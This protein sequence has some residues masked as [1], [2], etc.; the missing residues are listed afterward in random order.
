LRIPGETAGIR[1]PDVSL[2]AS[3]HPGKASIC[4]SWRGD[5]P[6]GSGF[7]RKKGKQGYPC[8]NPN[9]RFMYRGSLFSGDILL[10]KHR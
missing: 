10:L 6:D 1:I 5:N 3:R 2:H 9:S 4:Q 8:G 7:Q